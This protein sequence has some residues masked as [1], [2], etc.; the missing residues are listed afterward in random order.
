MRLFWT[1]PGGH[2]VTEMLRHMEHGRFVPAYR[3][4]R[5]YR[6]GPV[7]PPHALWRLG[8]WLLDKG[9]VKKARL[10]LETFLRLYPHH[11][12][13]PEVRLDLARVLQA[14]GATDEAQK[15]VAEANR[16]GQERDA[17]RQRASARERKLS[18]RAN[19]VPG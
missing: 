9:R 3:A 1:S 16:L 7:P 12:D 18:R 13:Q 11:Q 6:T 2:S 8:R 4:L 10:P 5:R 17:R 19:P 14:T 15:M